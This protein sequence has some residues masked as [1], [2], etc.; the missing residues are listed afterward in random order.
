MEAYELVMV[1]SPDM[2]EESTAGVVN[3]VNQFITDRGGAL[4]KQDTWGLR[5][6]AY[7]ISKYK[8][9]NY[10]LTLFSLDAGHTPELE[11]TLQLNASV[12]R[13]LLLRKD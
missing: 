6:L 12:L 10:F 11:N 8:E 13:H 5:R 4:E 9:G 7:P 2:D 3:R 1:L